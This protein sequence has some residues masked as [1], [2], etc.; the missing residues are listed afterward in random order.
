[1]MHTTARASVVAYP[2]LYEGF[3]FPPLEAMALGTPVVASDRGSLPEVLGGAAS[4]VDPTD[5]GALGGALDAVLTNRDLRARLRQTGVAHART[6]TWAKCAD[7]THD[8]YRA[9]LAPSHQS[10]A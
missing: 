4:L 10:V 2:S 7:R 9:V 1:M 8:V 3:G 6:Y 5:D